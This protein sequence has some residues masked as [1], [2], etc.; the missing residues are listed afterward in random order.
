MTL[1]E[2]VFMNMNGLNQTGGVAVG[3]PAEPNEQ[4]KFVSWSDDSRGKRNKF[5]IAN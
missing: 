4:I 5:Y 1:Y 2:N 3:T